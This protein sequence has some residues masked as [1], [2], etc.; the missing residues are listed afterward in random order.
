VLCSK[1]IGYK[2]GLPKK[3]EDLLK[4]FL[5]PWKLSNYPIWHSFS[6]ITAEQI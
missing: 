6:I 3:M 4:L 2:K 1:K 5:L